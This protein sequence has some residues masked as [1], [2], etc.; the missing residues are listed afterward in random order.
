[1]ASL[2][3]IH[4]LTKSGDSKSSL[5]EILHISRDKHQFVSL[6]RVSEDNVEFIIFLILHNN[7]LFQLFRTL[8]SFFLFF[9]AY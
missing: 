3:Q 2:I 5:V 9:F 4:E 7:D 8:T 6:E 1:M